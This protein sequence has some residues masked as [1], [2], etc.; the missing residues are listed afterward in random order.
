MQH[1]ITQ[2]KRIIQHT[3]AYNTTRNTLASTIATKIIAKSA[4]IAQL[5]LYNA[6][7]TAT[8][9]SKQIAVNKMLAKR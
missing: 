1:K 7:H 3:H 2:C 8:Q 5:T 9:Q 6:I 4:C